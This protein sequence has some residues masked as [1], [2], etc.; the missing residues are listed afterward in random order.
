MTALRNKQNFRGGRSFEPMLITEW[1]KL[2]GKVQERGIGQ[3]KKEKNPL[4]GLAICVC[5]I[6]PLG[7]TFGREKAKRLY[8]GTGDSFW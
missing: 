4:R 5:V 3:Y 6:A 1:R 2:G 8:S 7:G